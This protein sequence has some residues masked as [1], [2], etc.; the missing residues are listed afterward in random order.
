[1]MSKISDWKVN[2]LKRDV[3]KVTF[4]IARSVTKEK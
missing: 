1:M 3:N 2:L 4:F